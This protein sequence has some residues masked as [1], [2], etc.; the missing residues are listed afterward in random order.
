MRFFTG[1]SGDTCTCTLSKAPNRYSD[2]PVWDLKNFQ[3]WVAPDLRRFFASLAR[4]STKGKAV[5][6]VC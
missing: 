4:T 6:R 3:S 1:P 2:S 5:V